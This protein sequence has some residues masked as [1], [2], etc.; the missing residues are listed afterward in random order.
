VVETNTFWEEFAQALFEESGDAL[1][2]FDPETEQVQ[3]I[4]PVAQRLCGTTRKELR[5]HKITYLF[6]AD[7][8]NGLQRLRHAFRRT[9]VFHSQEG[10]WLRGAGD[11]TWLPVNITVTRLHLAPR[12]LGLV[13]A[14][15]IREQREALARIQ[16]AESELRR[17]LSSVSDCLWSAEIDET[18]HWLY[19][20]FSPVVERIAGRPPAYYASL[21]RWLDSVHPD[22]RLH[23]KQVYAGLR[24]GRSGAEEYRVVRP[25]GTLR[26]VRDSVV[27]TRGSNGRP[28]LVDGVLTDITEAH[29]ADEALRESESRRRLLLEQMPAIVWTTDTELKFT[30]GSGAGLAQVRIDPSHEGKLTLALLFGTD[31]P[32]F[33]P[34]A[35]HRRA[36]AGESVTFDFDWQDHSYH[37][38]VEPLYDPSAHLVGTIGVA[39]DVTER[40]RAETALRESEAWRQMLLERMPAIVIT[41]DT[42]MNCTSV[43]GAG[44]VAL[45]L[46]PDDLIGLTMPE[47][48]RRRGITDPDYVPLV[49]LSRALAGDAMNFEVE[50]EGRVFHAHTEPLCD[51]PRIMGAIGVAIDITE[52]K[53]AESALRESEAWRRLLLE[54]IPAIVWTTDNDM[55]VTSSAGA[56]LAAL[57]ES[58]NQHTGVLL[59]EVFQQQGITDPD[60]LPLTATRRA[61]T[62]EPVTYDLLYF[63]R[64][65][66]T[67]IEPLRD[68]SGQVIG[69]IGLS[70]DNTEKD[71]AQ[72]AVRASESRYRNL[73]EN[74]DQGI[75]LKDRQLRLVAVNPRFGQILGRSEA[76]I[77]GKTARD[78]YPLDFAERLEADDH[79]VLEQGRRIET[80]Y[81]ALLAN[82]LRTIHIVKTPVRDE[83]GSVTGVLGIY[84]DVT[85][86]RQLELQL[87]QS[88]KMEAIGQLA[89]GIA[90][91]FNNLLQ[92]ILGNLELAQTRLPTDHPCQE[93]LNDSVEA[94]F[95]GAE[96]TQQLLS[97]ARQSPLRSE[98]LDLN[99]CLEESIRLLSRSFDPR[100]VFQWHPNPSLWLAQADAA[101]MSQVIF[102]LCLNARDAMPA[103]GRLTLAA[104]NVA[105]TEDDITTLP[106]A[107]PG[108]FVCLRVA[109][110]G[111]GIAPDVLSHIF[112]PFFTTKDV[113]KG[114]GMGLAMVFGI[115]QQHEGWIVCQSELGRG[116][117]FEIFLPR[118]TKGLPVAVPVARLG[119]EGGETLLLADDQEM[120]RRLIPEALEGYGYKVLT[121]A[122]GAQALEL[123]CQ[124]RENIALVL[125]DLSMPALSGQDTLEELRRIDPS[126]R[127]LVT[128][129]H[130]TDQARLEAERAGAC[131]FVAKP[132][133]IVELVRQIRAALGANQVAP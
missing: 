97:F 9:G 36:L 65:F 85:D 120:I 78:L 43:A 27:V 119:S 20:Y 2:L 41:I 44:L 111:L 70:L 133:R 96:L 83:S 29:R 130:I 16:R 101:Q 28:A 8:P 113:G 53:R 49:A 58:P 25:D 19:C 62:G 104:D 114:T 95:R 121:A 102:N 37:C 89:S 57:G 73:I 34:I 6:R 117:T 46:Q 55:R 112:E 80:E 128:S 105:L 75:F 66:R 81:V 122:D 115:V 116:T 71:R 127:V 106:Q 125:L 108:D 5:Q 110:N 74:L 11:G 91:D 4:N 76:D 56:A 51:G 30:S 118:L 100:V 90:H 129:G 47:F 86:Q 31:D 45:G 21:E 17:V 39:L 24:E 84:W 7:V 59:S 79:L 33:L 67:H 26:W 18:G 64:S 69:T 50:F 1:F 22:D 15:D 63:E 82:K 52:R 13:T 38:H 42:E 54:R 94:G 109:D 92:A 132:F 68:Q 126:V 123:Y 32:E 61:L 40:K 23:V 87:R 48:F 98:A 77:L 12:T 99:R 124:Q 93:L 3:D 103:G 72:L 60:Y 10:F 35:A 88:H 14:R 107:R 131:G